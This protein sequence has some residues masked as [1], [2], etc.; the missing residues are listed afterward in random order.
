MSNLLPILQR[1]EPYGEGDR[2]PY[3]VPNDPDGGAFIIGEEGDNILHVQKPKTVLIPRIEIA[4]PTGA[5]EAVRKNQYGRTVNNYIEQLLWAAVL[6][7]T[8]TRPDGTDFLTSVPESRVLVALRLQLKP[9]DNLMWLLAN[10]Q[11]AL[12]AAARIATEFRAS[13]SGPMEV[14]QITGTLRGRSDPKPRDIIIGT[15]NPVGY[16]LEPNQ[17]CTVKGELEH[18]VHDGHGWLL[19]PG[20]VAAIELVSV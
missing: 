20:K 11:R 8:I 19:Y 6:Q 13:M 14:M 9:S 2:I 5:P 7:R 17:P 18:E 3:Q 12:D 16:Y 15:T 4:V 10:T 1:V